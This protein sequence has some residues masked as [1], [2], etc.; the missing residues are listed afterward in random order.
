VSVA[1]G[2]KHSDGPLSPPSCLESDPSRPGDSGPG[3][4]IPPCLESD[5]SSLR[6]LQG[7]TWQIGV[8]PL[9]VEATPG[10]SSHLAWSRTPRGHCWHS[11]DQFGVGP[12]EAT[13][14]R[15]QFGVQCQVGPLP[16]PLPGP[17]PFWLTFFSDRTPRSLELDT[18]TR[19]WPSWTRGRRQIRA[20]RNHTIM[21]MAIKQLAKGWFTQYDCKTRG[22][23]QTFC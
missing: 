20:A 1:K 9:R 4:Q 18:R 10:L 5:P 7:S 16:R 12:L 14:G 11:G 15:D 22:K 3:A 21:M 23:P 2:S 17:R 8:G 6:P 13:P 19:N